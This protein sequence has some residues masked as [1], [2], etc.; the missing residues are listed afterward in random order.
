M[1]QLFRRQLGAFGDFVPFREAAAAARCRG[2]LGD[3]SRVAAHGGLAAVVFWLRGGEA[4]GQ[5]FSRVSE[6]RRQAFFFEIA[7]LA[8]AEAEP[9]A[10]RRAS[11][12]GEEFVVVWH[13]SLRFLS[14]S[15][16]CSYPYSN[17]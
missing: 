6:H 17:W 5:K 14:D 15:Y 4:I 16:S 7:A 12:L 3:E 9:P 8:R 1:R 2:V 11:Q 10:K 13:V